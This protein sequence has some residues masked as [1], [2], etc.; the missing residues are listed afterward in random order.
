MIGK[1]K[2]CTDLSLA[3]VG[4]EGSNPFA[5]SIVNVSGPDHVG[6]I[7]PAHGAPV[8][9]NGDSKPSMRIDW[10]RCASNQRLHLNAKKSQAL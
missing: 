2:E 1:N 9:N 7:R 8:L 10:A 3:K 5:R 4:V 6:R